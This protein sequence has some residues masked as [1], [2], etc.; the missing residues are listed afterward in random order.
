MYVQMTCSLE[1]SN[2]SKEHTAPIYSTL[3]TKAAGSS[4]LWATN[5]HST[6]YYYLTA[7]GPI[8]TTTRMRTSPLIR[9][10]QALIRSELIHTHT[11]RYVYTHTHTHKQI[12]IYTHTHT[13]TYIYIYIYIY[14]YPHKLNYKKLQQEFSWY[15]QIYN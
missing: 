2:V 12:C 3:K 15:I 9:L 8:L 5:Y 14:I 13:H 7:L 1:G 6:Q 10:R 4:K 11:N